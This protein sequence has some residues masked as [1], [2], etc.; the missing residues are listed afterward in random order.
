MVGEGEG[1]VSYSGRFTSRKRTPDI[2]CYLD[3]RLGGLQRKSGRA[4]EEKHPSSYWNRDS[5]IQ[6]I[7]PI[8]LIVELHQHLLGRT[9][10]T[11][12]KP[13]Y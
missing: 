13:H 11:H 1:S 8:T 7:D 2:L 6:P 5:V 10:E 9:E 3:K 12:R 4:D